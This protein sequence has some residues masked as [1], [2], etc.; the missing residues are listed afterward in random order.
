MATCH[1]EEWR[2]KACPFM[3]ISS[4]QCYPGRT[5]EGLDLLTNRQTR[6]VSGFDT[7]LKGQ[8]LSPWPPRIHIPWTKSPRHSSGTSAL[9]SPL[10]D[11]V[12]TYVVS[13][14]ENK[15]WSA[16]V[17]FVPCLIQLLHLNG[18]KSVVFFLDDHFVLI[19]DS[20]YLYNMIYSQKKSWDKWMNYIWLDCDKVHNMLP[21]CISNMKGEETT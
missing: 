17:G 3:R 2:E 5:P 7:L 21:S 16:F 14:C 13:T 15:M 4:R 6:D 9:G 18:R 11:R 19:L 10:W 12:H 1:W 20:L 8:P